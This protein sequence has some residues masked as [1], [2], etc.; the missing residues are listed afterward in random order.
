MD[1][2]K[3]LI[4][5]LHSDEWDLEMYSFFELADHCY[6]PYE[7]TKDHGLICLCSEIYL[8]YERKSDE[9][10]TDYWSLQLTKQQFHRYFDARYTSTQRFAVL[11][12]LWLGLND[13]QIRHIA[14][15]RQRK[16]CLYWLNYF[17]CYRNASTAISIDELRSFHYT[18]KYVARIYKK[19]AMYQPP[20]QPTQVALDDLTQLDGL[21]K[22][23]NGG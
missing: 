2:R 12:G 4:Y 13:P 22:R 15:L 3:L 1:Y 19:Q 21:L 8:E 5:Y 20:E 9:D 11:F 16:N 7:G 14:D 17:L 23:R 6:D 18:G 10:G